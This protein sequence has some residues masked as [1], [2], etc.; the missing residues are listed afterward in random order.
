MVGWLQDDHWLDLAQYANTQATQLAKQIATF[1]RLQLVWPVESNE[2]FVIMPKGLAVH[3][4]DAGA[5]F[6]DW[7]V[8]TLPPNITIGEQ[9]IFAR[10]V[11]SFVTQ[12]TQREA[13]C[14][15]IQNYFA[16]Q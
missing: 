8:T 5:E 3:L 14:D 7:Y 2:L 12:D 4:Q 11:T 13:F 1:D 10:L 15:L 6:Y 16:V 9:E